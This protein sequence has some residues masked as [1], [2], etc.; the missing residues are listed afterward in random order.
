VNPLAS[1]D[2]SVLVN[3]RL[4]TVGDYVRLSVMFCRSPDIARYQGPFVRAIAPLLSLVSFG[5]SSLRGWRPDIIAVEC[6]GQLIGG[7]FLSRFGNF[8]TAVINRS[9]PLRRDC[10]EQL[11]G[12]IDRLFQER[13]NQQFGYWTLKSSLTQA[14]MLRGFRQTSRRRYVV[15][16]ALGP[17]RCSWLAGRP[18]ARP[19]LLSSEPMYQ[20]VKESQRPF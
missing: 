10:Y 9:H 14:G 20:M 13:P 11:A 18:I 3:Q 6:E 5:Y 4:A 16:A 17:L 12:R 2:S 19:Y 15:T 8:E 1:D 7:V